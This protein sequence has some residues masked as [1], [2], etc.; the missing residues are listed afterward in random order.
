[1]DAAYSPGVAQALEPNLTPELVGLLE[2]QKNFLLKWGFI[3][4]DFSVADWV[5]HEPLVEARRLAD[6]A[7]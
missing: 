7:K 5:A 1:M 6:A 3:Q 2:N 4:D